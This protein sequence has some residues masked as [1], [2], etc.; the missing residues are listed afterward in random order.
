MYFAHFTIWMW[1]LQN[2][3]YMY[4]YTKEILYM[5]YICISSVAQGIKL[6]F[7]IAIIK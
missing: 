6:K 7:C 2:Y 1:F 5:Y 4:L 3:L